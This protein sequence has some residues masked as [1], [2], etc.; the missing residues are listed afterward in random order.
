MN[1]SGWAEERSNLGRRG[2]MRAAAASAA[3]S[4]LPHRLLFGQAKPSDL[5]NLAVIGAG[6][7][8]ADNIQELQ[9]K[10][11]ANIVA[12]CDVD[13]ARAAKT[14]EQFPETPK[15]K[16]FRRLL[17][18]EKHIDAVLVATPDHM[19]APA[20]LAAMQL[21]KHVYCEKPLTHTVEEARLLT[22][23]AREHKVATQMGNQGMAF[24]GNR[25]L[26]EWI[27]AGVI[28]TVRE[29]H[30]WS[31]R[32]THYGKL[33]WAQGIER[34]SDRPPMPETLDWDLWLG[35]A[36]ERTYHPAYVPFAWRGW[37]DFGSGG[38][39][40][41]GIHNL[42]P[43]FSALQ[44]GAPVSVSASSTLFNEETL[45]L[46]SCV[47]YRFPARGE[48]PV[49]EVHWYDGGM[50][51]P[52]PE[53]LEPGEEL[54]PEDGLLFI[55]DKGTMLVEGWGG[56]R[57]RLLPKSR[58]DTFT[59]PPQ[60]LPRSIGH[61]AEWIEACKGGSP[62]RSNFD[63]AGPLT[64]AVLLGTV[65]VRTRK[66]LEWDSEKLEVTNVPEAA[67]YIRKQYRK[68]WSVNV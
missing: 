10:G 57:P 60:T 54:D 51:P 28:G 16:D 53:E 61:H 38:L 5:V 11:L 35:P 25:L 7:R 42:A 46:A 40:D 50:L 45:P 49:V 63:F 6:G 41:M 3:F 48:R 37:W 64:E 66:H 24:E 12:L 52:R 8:G 17:E 36:P 56:E 21:G 4:V 62:A 13:D 34:P 39:G 20:A 65:A 59:P 23:A 33:M 15:Y 44:L 22:R 43:V 58:M 18:Q 32:P 9:S 55:G 14:Y 68:G 31:D 2:F 26:N 27:D 30:G 19:H 1:N 67:R 29:V 47:H